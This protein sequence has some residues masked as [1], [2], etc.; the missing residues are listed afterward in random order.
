L[1]SGEIDILLGTQMI[2]KG[3]DLPRVTLVGVISA[4]S[5]LNIPDFRAAE[6]TFQLL[7]QVAGRAGRG[8]KI[9]KVIFQAYDTGH[10]S[11]RFAKE[12]DY[13]SFY[14]EEIEHRETL[15]YPPFSELVKIGFSG[16]NEQ[17]VSAA[18]YDFYKIVKVIQQRLAD[19]NDSTYYIEILG[20]GPTLIPKIQNNYRWQLLIKT[21]QPAWLPVIIKESWAEYQKQKH[22]D[23]KVIKDRNPYLVV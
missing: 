6:R 1:T 9:G 14:R 5:T 22:Q 21:N 2:A 16:L 7:T 4:D 10:Y 12:H 8:E 23:I 19:P 17:K 18:A 11:L 3:L 13:H 20:P 15:R